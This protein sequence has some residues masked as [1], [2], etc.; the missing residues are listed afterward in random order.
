M[1]PGPIESCD[2]VQQDEPRGQKSAFEDNERSVEEIL[3]LDP[4]GTT[5]TT[6]TN[7][8]T[9]EEYKYHYDYAHV[10]LDEEDTSDFPMTSTTVV[11]LIVAVLA[12]V[13]AV[14]FFGVAA[15]RKAARDRRQQSGNPATEDA[16][17]EWDVQKALTSEVVV[18]DGAEVEGGPIIKN[19]TSV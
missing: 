5:T 8:T 15:T 9:E 14:G 2:Q 19:Q 13:V 1:H 7:E 17:T 6:T 3:K 10:S 11:F 4:V 18:E 12:V 16:S